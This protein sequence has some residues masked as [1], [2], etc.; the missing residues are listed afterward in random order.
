M[1]ISKS[2]KYNFG[3]MKNGENNLITDVKG[4]RVGHTTLIDGDIQT[5]VT[6]IIP[7]EDNIFLSKMLCASHVVNGFG[8]SIGLVQIDELG[9]LETPILLT[10]TFSVPAAS[11][12]LLKYMI[13]EN[14][15][16]GDTTSTVNPVVAECNDGYLNDIRGMHIT[17]KDCLN[18]IEN[19]A[20]VF[21]EGAVGAGRG[22]TC[23]GLKG[24]IGSASRVFEINGKE[25]TLGTLLLTNFGTIRDLTLGGEKIGEKIFQ[26]KQEE[27]VDKGS[28]IIVI[29][30]DAPL[31]SRQLKRLCK[32]AQ[33][34]LARTG[35]ISG[36]GSGEISIAFTTKNRVPHYPTKENIIIECIHDDNIN[37]AFRAVIE[38]VEESVASSILQAETVIGRKGHQRISFNDTLEK[39]NLQ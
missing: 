10:N 25:Y 12:A 29:A 9:T 33:S 1:G 38:C 3:I 20:A 17:E 13:K 22:M 24:G 18:A 35:T 21:S 37:P 28:C 32:R 31:S 26:L 8:K 16:I 15:D 39:Y 7:S 14:S 2:C 4:V 23:Y 5:G 30:T 34:G 11:S 19:A 27:N 36:N 6:A